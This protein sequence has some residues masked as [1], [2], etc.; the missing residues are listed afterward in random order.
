MVGL[1]SWNPDQPGRE[2]S[3][4][5]VLSSSWGKEAHIQKG[6]KMKQRISIITTLMFAA[7]FVVG[8]SNDPLTPCVSE[9]DEA[10]ISLVDE[11]QTV[12]LFL[13]EIVVQGDGGFSEASADTSD[14]NDDR[15]GDTPPPPP[16]PKKK[17]WDE[18]K[19]IWH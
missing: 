6:L 17:T 13:S 16:P 14:G 11:F 10:T 9:N 12:N 18:I 2:Y 3:N 1:K 7:L 4:V 19:A 15:G 5:S 8:C